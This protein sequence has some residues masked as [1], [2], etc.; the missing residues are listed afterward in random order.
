MIDIEKIVLGLIIKRGGDDVIADMKTEYFQ[1]PINREIFNTLKYLF[2]EGETIDVASVS[3]ETKKATYVV[4]LVEQSDYTAGTKDELDK[5]VLEL[6]KSYAKRKMLHAMK[7]AYETIRESGIID[8]KTQLV[9][10]LD[11]ID[12]KDTKER[13]KP[14]KESLIRTAQWLEKQFKL[15]EEEM[16]LTTQLPSFNKIIGGLMPQNLIFI[17]ARPSVGKTAFSMDIARYIAKKGHRALFV[18]LEMSDIAL[19]TRYIAGESKMDMQKIRTGRLKNR[20]WAKLG[21]AIE[22]LSNLDIVIDDISRKVSDIKVTAKEMQASGG[23]DLI[24]VDYIQLLQPEGNNHNREQ[25]VASISRSLKRLAMDLDI[26][27]IALSQLSRQAEGKRPVLSDLRESGSQEQDADMV[28]FLWE[29]DEE[30][31]E[32]TE[33]VEWISA[34]QQ[35][36][37]LGG[38]MLELV[39]AKQRNGPLGA[40]YMAYFPSQTKFIELSNWEEV[41]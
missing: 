2:I 23:L 35:T 38:R 5:L 36:N 32:E 7:N 28:I 41:A 1:N 33:Q 21:Q 29:P 24:V 37:R 34:K 8:A 22:K 40:I 10:D 16:L 26:P 9:A 39:V 30:Y 6:K 25:E 3:V 15:Q 20:D 27:V 19:A 12:I 31:L 18:S 13:P 14:L 11:Q 4:E 17:A